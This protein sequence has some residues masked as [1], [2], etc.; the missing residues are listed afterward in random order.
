MK[1]GTAQVLVANYFLSA[2][3]GLV[4]SVD[5]ADAGW[6]VGFC[7]KVGAGTPPKGLGRLSAVGAP[8]PLDSGI[9]NAFVIGISPFGMLKNTK[10]D[11]NTNPNTKLTPAVQFRKSSALSTKTHSSKALSSFSS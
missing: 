9:S 1:S 11:E 5:G 3:L 7:S 6:G 8:T 2:S 4:E 10:I